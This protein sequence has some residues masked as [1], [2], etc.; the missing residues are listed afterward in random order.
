MSYKVVR[1]YNINNRLEVL[2]VTPFTSLI[3]LSSKSF[4]KF[5]RTRNPEHEVVY[6]IV[7]DTHSAYSIRYLC[8]CVV[9]Y[10]GD[11]RPYFD[12]GEDGR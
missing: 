12:T 5:D 6:V 8:N 9:T 2:T 4:I 1:R 10:L 7:K 11:P 3:S